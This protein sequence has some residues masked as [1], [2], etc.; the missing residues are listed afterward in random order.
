MMSKDQAMECLAELVVVGY[1]WTDELVE[2]YAEA[3][4]QWDD[5]DA[6]CQACTLLST[7][8]TRTSRVPL[9]VIFE[10]YKEVV[11][12]KA[13]DAPPA[14]LAPTARIVSFREGR[15]IAAEAYVKQCR[16]DGREPN[17]DFFDRFIGNAKPVP[18]IR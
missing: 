9:G 14:L 4:V 7:E 15:K 5:A 10:K 16:L 8:W 17:M 12:R 3:M 2:A 6:A 18:D 11:R 13:M 1:G